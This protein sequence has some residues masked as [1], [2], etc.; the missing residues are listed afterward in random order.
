[1]ECNSFNGIAIYTITTY[2]NFLPRLTDGGCEQIFPSLGEYV[3]DEVAE[4]GRLLLSL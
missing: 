3:E 1:M 4:V 2:N